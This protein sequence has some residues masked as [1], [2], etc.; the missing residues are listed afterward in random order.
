[1]TLSDIVTKIDVNTEKNTGQKLNQQLPYDVLIVGSGPAGAS[2]AI[3]AARKGIRTGIIGERF[4][5]QVLDTIDIENY[6][7]VSKTEGPK[8]AT[9]LRGHVNDYDIDIIDSQMVAKLI[10][11]DA[12]DKLHK[13]ETVSGATLRS[14]SIIIAIGDKWLDM[15][16]PGEKEYRTKGVTY[17]PHCYGS[18]F[19]GK[20]VAVIGGGNSGG[21]AA[22]D[23]AGVVEH[24]TLLEFTPEMRADAVL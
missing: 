12:A 7:S 17:C 6:I 23:L 20:R 18:L 24:V 1:M 8:L 14:R 10:P 11:A 15:N 21:E 22:I 13:I 9:A 19:K 2:A 3:Y 16:L 5:G 4:G